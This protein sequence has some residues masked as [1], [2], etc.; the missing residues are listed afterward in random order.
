M[1]ILR[2]WAD[3]QPLTPH[4]FADLAVILDACSRLVVGWALSR[5]IN[6]A[7]T[8]EALQAPLATRTIAP[9]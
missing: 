1:E 6:A 4:D 5:H 2:R 9:A 8:L 7:L 3:I